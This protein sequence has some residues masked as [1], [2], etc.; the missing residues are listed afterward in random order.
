M[1]YSSKIWFNKK[2]KNYIKDFQPDIV[3]CFAIAEPFRYNIV[4]YAKKYTN[5]KVVMWVADDVYGQTCD[6]NFITKNIY[7]K[8]YRE[9]FAM[10]D[11][12]YGVSQM[13]CEEYMNLYNLQI[14]PLYKGC[15]LNPCKKK[16][17][18]PI[19]MVY[20]GNLLYGRDETLAVLATEIREINQGETKIQL[21]VYSGTPVSEEIRESLSIDGCSTLY[22]AQ[23]YEEIKRIMSEADIVLHVESFS[24]E[25][26][27]KVRLSFSTKIVDC[28]QSGS[29][30]MVIGP[31]GIASVEYPRGIDGVFVVDDLSELM[32]V[33]DGIVEN[34]SRIITNAN[35]LSE[36]A[37]KNHEIS[38]VRSKLQKDFHNVIAS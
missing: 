36:Y 22:A 24:K 35:K 5:A 16:I 37:K 19:Q 34:P 31:K 10:V 30:M 8:R 23:P 15:D 21:S 6:M 14:T 13:L 28:M 7:R 11:K 9:M 33:I 27:N 25:Q 29:A 4:K 38:A 32:R 17:G 20:A 1:V 2:L 3:F 26:I 12:V 18:N